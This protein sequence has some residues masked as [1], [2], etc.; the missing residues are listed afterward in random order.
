MPKP[1]KTK[2]VKGKKV[3]RLTG[4]S[5]LK[6]EKRA[7]QQRLMRSGDWKGLM[8]KY[9]AL[10][11]IRGTAIVIKQSAFKE[12][13]PIVI[14]PWADSRLREKIKHYR[15]A[16]MEKS[17][18]VTLSRHYAIPLRLI[19]RMQ[20]KERQKEAK[21]HRVKASARF[22]TIEV[23]GPEGSLEAEIAPA[24]DKR[25][26]IKPFERYSEKDL[27]ALNK[28]IGIPLWLLRML[29]ERE[30]EKIG[31]AKQIIKKALKK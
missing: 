8:E 10:E 22:L 7:E 13:G 12:E 5:R 23:I 11:T 4:S 30:R 19:E 6:P 1:F 3:N 9:E 29:R 21:K 28:K 18:L 31:K 17:E 2:V 16:Y 14:R 15:L 27:K 26:N 25:G 20:R 24:R